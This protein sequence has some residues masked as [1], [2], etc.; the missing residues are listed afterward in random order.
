M[1]TVKDSYKPFAAFDLNSSK[2]SQGSEGG[3][4]RPGRRRIDDVEIGGAGCTEGGESDPSTG[5]GVRIKILN[6]GGNLAVWLPKV[7]L[8][9]GDRDFQSP[10]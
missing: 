3:Q 1:W 10:F 2:L 8:V 9:S 4:G 6:S 5:E 7:I